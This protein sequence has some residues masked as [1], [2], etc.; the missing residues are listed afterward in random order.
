MSVADSW[1]GIQGQIWGFLAR[2][3]FSTVYITTQDIS[4]RAAKPACRSQAPRSQPH[5][6]LKRSTSTLFFSIPSL[7]L[8]LSLLYTVPC[9]VLWGQNHL[10][11]ADFPLFTSRRLRNKTLLTLNLSNI[12]CPER[13]YI[14]CV[15]CASEQFNESVL[16]LWPPKILYGAFRWNHLGN[17]IEVMGYFKMTVLAL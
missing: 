12:F 3:E 1:V 16:K 6:A 11:C 14:Q 4:R 17:F 2:S 7:C 8:P 9:L 15:R 5:R 13:Q 10:Y